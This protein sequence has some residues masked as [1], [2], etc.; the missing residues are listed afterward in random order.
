MKSMFGLVLMILAVLSGVAALI[1]F[2]IALVFSDIRRL[3]AGGS[4]GITDDALLL[5]AG[6]A[7]ASLLLWWGGRSLRRPARS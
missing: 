4:S 7:V 5:I 3:G 1:G 6:F 2:I